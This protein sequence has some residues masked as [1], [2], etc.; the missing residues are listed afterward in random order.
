MS[1]PMDPP[2]TVCLTSSHEAQEAMWRG[3]KESLSGENDTNW[4]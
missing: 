2:C 3:E 4:L 1:F